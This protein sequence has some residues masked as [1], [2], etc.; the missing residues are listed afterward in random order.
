MAPVYS[1]LGEK[2]TDRFR[3][4]KGFGRIGPAPRTVFFFSENKFFEGDMA[5]QSSVCSHTTQYHT[6]P[7]HTPH[8]TPYSS[9]ID[10]TEGP[11]KSIHGWASSRSTKEAWQLPNKNSWPVRRE[12]GGRFGGWRFG[13]IGAVSGLYVPVRGNFGV[14]FLQKR[15]FSPIFFLTPDFDASRPCGSSQLFFV[16]QLSKLSEKKWGSRCGKI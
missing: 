5:S 7:H 1:F 4:L 10:P 3:K 14:I 16:C 6:Q 11:P 9:P 15:P 12:K 8:T 2:R 13:A